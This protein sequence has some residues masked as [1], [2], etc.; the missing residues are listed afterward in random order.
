M[1]GLVVASSGSHALLLAPAAL[2][3]A[4]L[5]HGLATWGS[6]VLTEDGRLEITNPDFEPALHFSA[7]FTFSG[8]RQTGNTGAVVLQ[9][10][11]IRN[12]NN[13][14]NFYTLFY[15]DGMEEILQPIVAAPQLMKVLAA[16]QLSAA[17]DR[18]LGV[19]TINNRSYRPSYF[20]E[21][22]G[23]ETLSWLAANADS[24]DIAFRLEDINKD[25]VMDYQVI[26][27]TG[28]QWLFG[29]P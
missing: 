1:D 13:N 20:V 5:A 11:R 15:A 19:L 10:P 16:R 8:V 27:S 25:S 28:S 14:E 6:V 9:P 12:S 4:A 24:F 7:T 17:F 23:P 21:A 29:Q 2:D 22:L 18:N 3:P 26:S